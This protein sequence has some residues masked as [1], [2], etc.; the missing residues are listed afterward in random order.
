MSLSREPSPR[1]GGGWSSPG[2][3]DSPSYPSMNGRSKNSNITW[4]SAQAKSEEIN[5]GY[6]SYSTSH[7]GFFKR[8]IRNF[9]NQL[10]TFNKGF[11]EG[12]YAEKEKLGRGRNN[13]LRKIPSLSR[14]RR[15]KKRYLLVFGVVLFYIISLFTRE[16]YSFQM[17]GLQL[18]I[19]SI[20]IP[21]AQNTNAGRRK[22]VC[23]NTGC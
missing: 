20:E 18:T 19:L 5:Q 10:P 6:P 4:E 8:H 23:Y 1:A 13:W 7:G 2:L 15:T 3:N 11:D 12:N 22:E 9:S 14:L 16:L 17:L 21:L